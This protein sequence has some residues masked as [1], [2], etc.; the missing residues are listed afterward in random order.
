MIATH[1][2]TLRIPDREGVVHS[3]V[4]RRG[5]TNSATGWT[6]HGITLSGP[7]WKCPFGFAMWGPGHLIV[8]PLDS[9]V[10]PLELLSRHLAANGITADDILERSPWRHTR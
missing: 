5:G 2:P 4:L 10:S 1:G 7:M 9:S 6:S 8:S 3:F